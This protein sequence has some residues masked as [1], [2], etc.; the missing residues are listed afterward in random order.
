MI[1]I[2]IW[3]I[4][5]IVSTGFAAGSLYAL[6]LSSYLRKGKAKKLD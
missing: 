2:P 4:F 1:D 6:W 3:A 5:L